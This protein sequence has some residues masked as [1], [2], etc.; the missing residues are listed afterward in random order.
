MDEKL[1]VVKPYGILYTVMETYYL[2]SPEPIPGESWESDDTY[3]FVCVPIQAEAIEQKGNERYHV[4]GYARH[5]ITNAFAIEYKADLPVIR[6]RVLDEIDLT[7]T[8]IPIKEDKN[9][10]QENYPF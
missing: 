9:D 3:R 2:L 8:E 10:E 1:K 5:V 7:Q 4:Y 6:I